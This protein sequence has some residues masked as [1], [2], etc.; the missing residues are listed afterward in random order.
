MPRHVCIIRRRLIIRCMATALQVHTTF[1]SKEDALKVAR[2]LVTDQLAACAQVVDGVTSMYVW[3]E[4]LRHDEEVLLLLKTTEEAWPALRD[5]LA[6]LHPYD[7]PEI[8]ALPIVHGSFDY[9][10]WLKENTKA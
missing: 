4:M 6:K 2:A 9:L 1:A 7:T 8:V 3:E 10:A 5:R